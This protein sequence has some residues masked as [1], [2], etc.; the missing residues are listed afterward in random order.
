MPY[1]RRRKPMS[2]RPVRKYRRRTTLAKRSRIAKSVNTKSD[3]HYFK[4]MC[5]KATL[6]GDVSRTSR[7][8]FTFQLNDLPNVTEFTQLF[9]Y[10]N[11]RGVSLKFQLNLD[12]SAQA[13][14]NA[15]YP[16]MFSVID[17]DDNQAPTDTN[18]L[19]E[20]QWCRQRLLSPNRTY[21]IF[22]KPK[23]LRNVFYNN[24]S[25][26]YEVGKQT[27]LDLAQPNI[28]H[29]GLKYVIENLNA[30]IGQTVVV[31]AT[32]YLSFKGVR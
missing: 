20:R 3:I 14:A 15:T 5:F 16:R 22:L 12:P 19:R 2:K 29:F 7:G 6:A 24:L 27:W 23:Y 25:N 13:P 10:Y 28:P 8:A 9:D 26:G 18:E 1:Y 17:Y 30:E 21:T 32:Y 31:D 11:I 4:R